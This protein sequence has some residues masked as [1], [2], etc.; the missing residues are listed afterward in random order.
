V[1]KPLCTYI[2]RKYP[3]KEQV[4]QGLGNVQSFN[5]QFNKIYF[6]SSQWSALDI[7]FR[8]CRGRQAFLTHEDEDSIYLDDNPDRTIWESD[9]ICLLNC[10]PV[11]IHRKYV[12]EVRLCTRWE[13]N[14]NGLSTTT[15][16]EPTKWI[17][18]IVT[19]PIEA[20][21][22]QMTP[23]RELN[24]QTGYV[25][26]QKK[27]VDDLWYR[28]NHFVTFHY[29]PVDDSYP[30]GRLTVEGLVGVLV[31]NGRDR[32]TFTETFRG[33]RYWIYNVIH[34]WESMGLLEMGSADNAYNDLSH[35]YADGNAGTG[36]P[37]MIQAGRFF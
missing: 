8:R 22:I 15:Q 9:R 12:E 31:D 23:G 18:D 4:N 24:G 19:G 16:P 6:M 5:D 30:L 7:P 27:E 35:C 14:L 36:F 10:F 13:T 25:I 2:W 21:E 34:E 28:S 32:Y 33:R 3:Q 1:T 20:I 11:D 37:L 17:L 29:I 26:I